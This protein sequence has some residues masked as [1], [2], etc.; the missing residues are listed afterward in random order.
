[1][2]NFD[3]L[4]LK[5]WIAEN[6]DYLTN[7]SIRK[8]QQPSRRELILHLRNNAEN[9][10]LYLNINP[11]YFHVC[12]VDDF[13]KRGL[14][15]PDTAPM[16]CMLLRKYIL[17]GRISEVNQPFGERILEL[18]FEYKDALDEIK[19]LCLA[20]EL[21]GKYSN[22][23]LY[24]ID[25][26]LI[27][28]CA[29]NVG[30]EKSKIRELAGTLPYVYPATQNKI[31]I[32]LDSFEN[33]K[34]K[35]VGHCDINSISFELANT[36]AY[37]TVTMIK[38][39][40]AIL[41]IQNF[42]ENSLKK[43]FDLIKNT[44]SLKNITPSINN[45]FSEFT[46]LQNKSFNKQNSINTMLNNYFEFNQI[47]KI[48]KQKKA[49][50]Y[51]IIDTKNKKFLKQKEIFKL[52]IS[53]IEKADTYKIKGDILMMNI[54]ETVLPLIKL[55]NPYN[56]KNIEIELD[57]RLTIIQNANRYY[58]LYKKTKTAIEYASSQIEE[59]EN[60]IMILD[61]QRFYTDIA[62]SLTEI[63]EIS[64][65]LGVK[66]KTE[67][68]NKKNIIN[69]EN[70]EFQGFKIYLGKNS[71]QND[72]LLSKI[73]TPEDLWFHPLNMHGAHVILKKNNFKDIV[74]NEVLLF[75]AKL[76]KRFAKTNNDSKIPIIFTKRKYVKKANSKLA[77]VT[78]KNETEI[79]C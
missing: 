35:F 46:L 27:I 41:N 56:N 55:I 73:A 19:R 18:K 75:C 21:M 33:F 38:Q 69:L 34:T 49:K 15:I 12:F 62:S 54:N 5:A 4:T 40:F 20:I 32:N 2:I 22:I 11:E 23:I 47:A 26:G 61:E 63:D 74:P 45:D 50:L 59:I 42:D 64:T 58:K 14:L 1:M 76:T 9:K 30:E 17:N 31:D 79:Y 13:Q 24:D 6:K 65:I 7:A 72:Y 25:S 78:Y 28:G 77:F 36:Y 39:A 68:K 53:E 57:T 70:Y 16:F 44:V 51:N 60:Q 66:D 71:I 37:I 43:L 67:K 48:L 8:I 52:K 10:K 3:S 29:H